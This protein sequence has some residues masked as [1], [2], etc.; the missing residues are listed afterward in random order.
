MAVGSAVGKGV[1]VAGVRDGNGVGEGGLPVQLVS[2]PSTPLPALMF[3]TAGSENVGTVEL[4]VIMATV[5]V[6]EIKMAFAF[7]AFAVATVHVPLQK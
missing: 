2:R 7:W 4:P 5:P 3:V 1:G 6:G